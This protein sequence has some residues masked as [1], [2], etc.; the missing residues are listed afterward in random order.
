MRNDFLGLMHSICRSLVS[1]VICVFDYGTFKNGHNVQEVYLWDWALR[2][3]IIS[4]HFLPHP[5]LA[6]SFF[7]S[8][9]YVDILSATVLQCV[10]QHDEFC[11]SEPVG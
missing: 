8:F 4:C 1:S 5:C 7:V 2:V 10:F 11:T 9:V 6:R 3:D